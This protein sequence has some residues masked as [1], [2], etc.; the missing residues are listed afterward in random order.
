MPGR[1]RADGYRCDGVL[2]R[3]RL[4]DTIRT[5]EKLLC[6][7]YLG[8][9]YLGPRLLGNWYE[10]MCP[11]YLGLVETLLQR[12][13]KPRHW[14]IHVAHIPCEC[15]GMRLMPWDT[16]TLELGLGLGLWRGLALGLWLRV[17]VKG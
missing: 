13:L 2:L 9:L 6:P 17:R 12:D 4:D 1:L 7:L 15:P 8:P 14:A 16:S 11:L 3:A 5:V 10:H